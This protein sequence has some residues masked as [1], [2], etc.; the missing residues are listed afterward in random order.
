MSKSKKERVAMLPATAREVEMAR[1]C[2]I[3][4]VGAMVAV[5]DGGCR[6]MDEKSGCYIPHFCSITAM[7]PMLFMLYLTL[8]M[9]GTDNTSRNLHKSEETLPVGVE[10][11][12]AGRNVPGE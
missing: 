1:F 12:H 8:R 11:R 10:Q 3:S 7:M 5:S 4:A 2:A 9:G 6:V